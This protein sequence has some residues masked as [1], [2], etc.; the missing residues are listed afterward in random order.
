VTP[1]AENVRRLLR[2]RSVA[3]VGGSVA[4]NAL[5]EC[6]AAGFD[7]PVYAVDPTRAEVGGRAAYRTVRDLP[8]PP[9]A[10]FVA[11][12]AAASVEVVRELAT[13]GAG[14]AVVYAA[15]FAEA[16]SEEGRAREAALREAAGD[17]AVL[18]PNCYG[19]VDLVGGASLWPVP[20]PHERRTRGV[21]MVLQSG[22]LGINVSMSQRSLPLAFLASVGN[23]AVLDVPRVVDA[24][25]EM[26]EVT[27]I[28]L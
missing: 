1:A 17:L 2:P 7:G 4:P 24:Y 15:G 5:A 23:Q 19:I 6:L 3:F 12:N 11:V 28:G 13:L 8:E 18:G 16:G 25:L 20:Y 14:G 21:A 27:A 9:D 10:A 22:N 26:E